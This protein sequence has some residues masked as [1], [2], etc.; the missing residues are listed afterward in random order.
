K[1]Y[2][3]AIFRADGSSRFADGNRWGYFPSISGGWRISNE[4]FLEDN[5]TISN[6]K[7]NLGWGQL[8]NQNVSAFQYLNT[9]SKNI[10]Y[11]LN[12][13]NLTGTR[14]ASFANPDITW[15]T[16]SALN[17]LLELGLFQNKLNLDVAYFD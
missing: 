7:L 8:G 9:Y 17:I 3:S 5:A 14:L 10:R 13:T 6:M 16:T 2:L 11:T 4:S 12:V 1:Y 15:E